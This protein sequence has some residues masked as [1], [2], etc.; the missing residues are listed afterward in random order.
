M[1]QLDV[2]S[3]LPQLVWLAITFVALYLLMAR[4]ALPRIA[5]VLAERSKRR[6][7]NLARAEDLQAEAEAAAEAYENVLA[8]ARTTA[9]GQIVQSSEAAKVNAEDA[10]HA[11]DQRLAGE[12]EAAE[13]TIAAARDAAL[14]EAATIAAEAARLAAEKIAGI[15]ID[16][17]AAAAAALAATKAGA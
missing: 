16:S 3:Y 12:I 1:P 2:A 6:E 11:L 13:A 7:D 5:D 17:Q 4:L 9:H 15:K 8:E 14:T 10:I